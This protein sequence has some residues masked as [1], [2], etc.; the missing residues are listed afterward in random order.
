VDCFASLA[1][2]DLFS[3]FDDGRFQFHWPQQKAWHV[4][5][6]TD[7]GAVVMPIV[8][9]IALRTRATVRRLMRIAVAP[10]C[11][12]GLARLVAMFAGRMLACFA[13]G[14]FPG[15]MFARLMLAGSTLPR[16]VLA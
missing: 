10:R 13:R 5:A 4:I 7:D 6:H 3:L 2:T 16:R 14:M 9:I 8:P 15:A 11:G 12:L 1:M